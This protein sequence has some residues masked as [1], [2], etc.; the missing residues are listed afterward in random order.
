[1]LKDTRHLKAV[2]TVFVLFDLILYI[3]STTFQLNRDG[4]WTK[5]YH[6]FTRPAGRVTN[7]FN[8]NSSCNYMHLSFKV[9]AKK[10]HKGVIFNMTSWSKSSQALILQDCL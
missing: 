6:Y 10:E 3:P 9:Y 4:Q 1:M 8:F 5:I 2:P 7:N